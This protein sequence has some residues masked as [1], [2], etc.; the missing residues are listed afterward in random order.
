[1]KKSLLAIGVV[2]ATFFTTVKAQEIT[3]GIDPKPSLAEI[4]FE[5]DV[6]DYGNIKQNANGT[7]EFKFKNTGKE[8]LIISMARGSCGCTVPEWPKE[9]IKPGETAS[10]K[11]NYDTK[12]V[13]AI[14][15]TVTITSNAKNDPSKTLTIKGNVE[16]VAAEETFPG[17]V[18]PVGA[19]LEKQ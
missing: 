13:G 18:T 14:N 10:I 19:P 1:M 4:T 6:H 3:T 7:C 16:A 11:V 15:K 9:P 12:R 2:V 5:K 17:K 8:P